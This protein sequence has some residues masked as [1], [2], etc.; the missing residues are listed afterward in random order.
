VDDLDLTKAVSEFDKAVVELLRASGWLYH[1]HR[2]VDRDSS[3]TPGLLD[4]ARARLAGV[5]LHEG[6]FAH[7][8]HEAA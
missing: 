3:A 8:Y 1:V 2:T 7:L 5:T 4:L 6:V